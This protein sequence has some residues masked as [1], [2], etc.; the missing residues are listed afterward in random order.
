VASQLLNQE[1]EQLLFPKDQTVASLT[2]VSTTFGAVIATAVVITF[3]P[4]SAQVV[5]GGGYPYPAYRYAAPDA[6][7]R[8]DVKPKETAVYLDGY[9]AGIV[10]D[11]DGAF[12]RLRTAPGGHLVTLYLEG[13]RTY[14]EQVYLGADNTFKLR[15]RMERLGAGDIAE[16]PPAPQPPPQY[17]PGQPPPDQGGV[18]PRGPVGRRGRPPGYPYPPDNPNGARG[19]PPGQAAGLDPNAHGTLS[20][21]LDPVD[22][23]LLVDGSPWRGTPSGGHLTIDLPVGRHNIQIRKPGFVGYLTDVQIRQDQSTNLD[24]KLK[25]QP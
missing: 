8:F 15:H 1:C 6:A 5:V 11:F 12:Q 21:A 3:A 7:M 22:A 23:E 17:Q 13:Y 16:R 24:V 4:L 25:P 9:Y 2:R 19:G 10:D 14:S 20:L 18:P